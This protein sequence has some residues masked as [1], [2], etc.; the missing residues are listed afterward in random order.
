MEIYN[1]SNS[2]HWISHVHICNRYQHQMWYHFSCNHSWCYLNIW[3][4]YSFCPFISIL[5]L[6]SL[7]FYIIVIA[8]YIVLILQKAKVVLP[9]IALWTTSL[10]TVADPGAL[11]EPCFVILH[12]SPLG[13]S[14]PQPDLLIIYTYHM[15]LHLNIVPQRLNC[16]FKM[17][18]IHVLGIHKLQKTWQFCHICHII[19]W[20]YSESQN[21]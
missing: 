4:G 7:S 16:L 6:V 17:P 9:Y 18:I 21:K 13:W 15:H 14:P 11:I 8:S 1:F 12:W 3:P 20:Y 19:S 10:L 2:H 5:T